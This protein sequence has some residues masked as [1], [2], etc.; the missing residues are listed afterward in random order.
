MLTHALTGDAP[1]WDCWTTWKPNWNAKSPSDCKPALQQARD[2]CQPLCDQC[3]LAMHRR[4]RYA[5]AIATSYGE[6]R[7]QIPVCVPLW[8]GSPHGRRND[9]VGR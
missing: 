5:R 7:V 8:A 1:L 2:D 4:H 9:V 6:V 3:R